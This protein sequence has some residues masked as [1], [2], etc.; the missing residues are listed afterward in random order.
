M[1]GRQVEGR[2]RRC[3][4]LERRTCARRGAEPAPCS[5][6][7]RRHRAARERA[8][9]RGRVHGA[10]RHGGG[11][12]RELAAELYKTGRRPAVWGCV[13]GLLAIAVTVGR[14]GPGLGVQFTKAAPSLPHCTITPS[15][16]L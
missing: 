2:R 6:R 8:L 1:W 15:L 5:S 16:E 14:G 7:P 13:L 4:Q 10:D 9:A 12:V 11:P 3:V